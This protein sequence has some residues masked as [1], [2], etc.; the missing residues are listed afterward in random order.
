[1]KLKRNVIVSVM[2]CL[3]FLSTLSIGVFAQETAAAVVIYA[4]GEGFEVIRGDEEILYDFESESA[5]GVTLRGGDFITT[6]ENTFVELQLY[7]SESVVK[8]SEN[9]S[10]SVQSVGESGGGFFSLT[11]G[12]LRAKVK[13]LFGGEEFKITGPSVVAGVRGTDFGYDRI[14][15]MKTPEITKSRV[16]CFEGVVEV[17]AAPVE[18][19]M[20]AGDAEDEGAEGTAGGDE[21][22]G[23]VVAGETPEPEVIVIYANQMVEVEE[24]DA[25]EPEVDSDEAEAPATPAP[26]RRLTMVKREIAEEIETYWDANVFKGRLLQDQQVAP[27]PEPEPVIEETAVEEASPVEEELVQAAEDEKAHVE[28]RRKIYVGSS[29]ALFSTG[30]VLEAAG[31]VTAFA[32]GSWIPSADVGVTRPLG[33][34]FMGAGGV[35]IAGGFIP[36]IMALAANQVEEDVE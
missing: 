8:V 11:Y 12:R 4:E 25:E 33:L 13:Q 2:V 14:F 29:I 18:T 34:T 23:T 30:A 24:L 7:P 21:A 17:S 31:A 15:D 19:G 27:E 16:Y 20:D 32:L 22:A 5:E 3:L 26:A 9:T 35:L 10:F 6:F 28:R 36:L 1:M